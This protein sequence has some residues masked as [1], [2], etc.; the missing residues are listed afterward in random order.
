LRHGQ[1]SPLHNIHSLIPRLENDFGPENRP[2][3]STPRW[4]EKPFEEQE[5]A[6]EAIPCPTASG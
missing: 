5:H 1:V 6:F 2:E 3:E 4:V